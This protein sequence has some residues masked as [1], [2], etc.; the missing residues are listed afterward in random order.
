MR[1]CP[2]MF[3][4]YRVFE[5]TWEPDPTGHEGARS[6]HPRVAE[7]R[8]SPTRDEPECEISWL[9]DGH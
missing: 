7:R 4:L 5:G 8:R 9:F 1:C 3:F 2:S 6:P